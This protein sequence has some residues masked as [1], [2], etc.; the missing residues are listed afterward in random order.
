MGMSD[1]NLLSCAPISDS[2]PRV[3]FAWSLPLAGCLLMCSVSRYHSSLL[4]ACDR[5]SLFSSPF[6]PG[7]GVLV[8]KSSFPSPHSTHP[9][10]PGVISKA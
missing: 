2:G 4:H 1:L 7:S 3:P 10:E 8:S 6:T 5:Q 9:L